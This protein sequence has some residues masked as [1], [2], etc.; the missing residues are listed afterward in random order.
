LLPWQK[1]GKANLLLPGLKTVKGL[2]EG[3]IADY[4][5]AQPEKIAPKLAEGW[6]ET[7]GLIQQVKASQL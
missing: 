3:A 6:K 1:N 2:V 5:A 7:D 4:S